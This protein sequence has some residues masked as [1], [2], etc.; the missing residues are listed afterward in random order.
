[1]RINRASLLAVL[2]SVQ[3]GLT[4]R[5]QLEQSS[6][7]GFQDG[8]VYTLNEEISCRRKSPLK[9]SGA[10]QAKPLL[11]IL[12]LLHEE[13][14]EVDLED[15]FLLVRGKGRKAKIRTQAE[16]LMPL[17]KVEE[18][19]DWKKLHEDF[20]DAVYVAQQCVGKDASNYIATCI[21]IHPKYIESCD[22]CQALRFKIKTKV[23]EPMLVR[24]SSIK[25]INGL[26]MTEFCETDNWI[27]F[28]NPTGLM[29]SCRR[30]LQAYEPLDSILAVDGV[31]LALPKGLGDAATRSEV[32][33]A[34]NADENEV[35]VQIMPGKLRITG[36]GV[37]GL[38][39]ETKKIKYQGEELSFR[40]GPKML[41][42]LVK[43]YTECT[44]SEQM[45]KV[46]AGKFVYVVALGHD[47]NKDKDSE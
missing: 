13:D 17:E 40:V 5:D 23:A 6:C 27:H 31:P 9:I 1:M 18:A 26:D 36:E 2:E 25:H 20:S 14:L 22:N 35:L 7:F 29:F 43:R 33:S 19:S 38:F 28:R 45:L 46:E 15:G 32:F 37:S 11:D 3:P 12:R 47:K 10:V 8:M 41:V 44:I 4:H 16:L 42:E 30:D 34:E 24:G 39:T 21:H